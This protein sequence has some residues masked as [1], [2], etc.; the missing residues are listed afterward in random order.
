[1]IGVSFPTTSRAALRTK[2]SASSSCS[3]AA[4]PCNDKKTAS[5]DPAA[6]RPSTSLPTSISN[7][8]CVMTPP[9]AAQAR[10]MGINSTDRCCSAT[11][12]RKPPNRAGYDDR[13]LPGSAPLLAKGWLSG[14]E[15]GSNYPYILAIECAPALLATKT[16]SSP[17]IEFS[18]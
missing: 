5:S 12:S 14:A 2:P 7:V 3:A 17:I 16:F 4:A 11:T 13:K 6:R 9:A 8:G 1:M 18:L 15:L 10:T